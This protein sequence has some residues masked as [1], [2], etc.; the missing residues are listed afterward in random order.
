MELPIE[1]GGVTREEQDPI[2]ISKHEKVVSVLQG[3]ILVYVGKERHLVR[4][5]DNIYFAS[6]IP[7]HFENPSKKIKAR[8]MIV[9]NPK[10]Y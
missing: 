9:Q 1:P 6:D 8:C 3:E 5:G 2:D 7:H 10:S 4:K